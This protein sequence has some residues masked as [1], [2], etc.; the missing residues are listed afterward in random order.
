MHLNGSLQKKKKYRICKVPEGGGVKGESQRKG[1]TPEGK[2]SVSR[3]RSK[4]R[5]RMICEVNFGQPKPENKLHLK[6]EYEK[7]Q[8]T[9]KKKKENNSDRSCKN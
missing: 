2:Y 7:K 8:Q 4:K 9:T 1:K 5:E 3:K 6:A